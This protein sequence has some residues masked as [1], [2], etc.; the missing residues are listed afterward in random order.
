MRANPRS[1]YSYEDYEFHFCSMNPL[2]T[3][4]DSKSLS[5]T[6]TVKSKIIQIPAAGPDLQKILG[7]NPKFSISSSY[8]YLK[9]ILS[10][11]LKIFI[12][13]TCSLLKQ[14]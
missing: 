9:F 6:W 4:W 11:K 14:S 10:Y 8:V 13:F 7:K 12:G 2:F 1:S 3:K 5:Q